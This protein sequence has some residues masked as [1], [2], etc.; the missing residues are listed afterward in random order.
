MEKVRAALGWALSRQSERRGHQSN[1][2]T[3][4]TTTLWRCIQPNS[5][6]GFSVPSSLP[7][8]SDLEPAEWRFVPLPFSYARPIQ[9]QGPNSRSLEPDPLPPPPSTSPPHPANMLLPRPNCSCGP[10]S[11][12]QPTVN[13]GSVVPIPHLLSLCPS[14]SST[15]SPGTGCPQGPL[16]CALC[17]FS[18]TQAQAVAAGLAGGLLL[19]P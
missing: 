4:P 18:N 9:G 3:S 6:D 19:D 12:A 7:P 10:S 8:P 17:S 5:G 14:A 15:V 11:P 2:R 13:P 1:K 16:P